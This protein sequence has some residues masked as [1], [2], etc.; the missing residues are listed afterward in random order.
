MSYASLITNPGG[1]IHEIVDERVQI[2][3]YAEATREA[4]TLHVMPPI[5]VGPAK[6]EA[7]DVYLAIYDEAKGGTP[8]ASFFCKQHIKPGQF[9][10]MGKGTAA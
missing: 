1:D 7:F 5:K 6:E 8:S 4:I 10:R 2:A 3:A 9:V